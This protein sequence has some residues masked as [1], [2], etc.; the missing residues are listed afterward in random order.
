MRF[1]SKDQVRCDVD[2]RVERLDTLGGHLDQRAAD[3]E[4]I[5][6][7]LSELKDGGTAEALRAVQDS[8][9]EAK[10]EVRN[11][12]EAEHAELETEQSEA[13]RLEQDVGCEARTDQD[14]ARE[15][16]ETRSDLNTQEAAEPLDQAAAELQE[17]AEVLDAEAERLRE[18]REMSLEEAQRLARRVMG[19]G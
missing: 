5:D 19:G 15:I 16:T 14:N 4:R 10:R 2:S 13:E 9:G 12:F 11:Q 1:D 17:D 18:R 7:L 6:E 8:V 3:H